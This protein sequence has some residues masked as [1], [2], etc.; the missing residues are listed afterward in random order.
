MT[1][2]YLQLPD[3][4]SWRVPVFDWPVGCPALPAPED[5]VAR[6]RERSS[7]KDEKE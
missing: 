2:E 6:I 7:V 3:S 5:L 1:P 4:W